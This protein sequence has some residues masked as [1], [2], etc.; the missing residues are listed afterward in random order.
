VTLDPTGIVE[1]GDSARPAT[2][3]TLF[4]LWGQPLTS[5]RLAGFRGAVRAYIDGRSVAGKPAQIELRRHAEI[6]LE[7]SGYV[8]PHAS[9]RFPNGL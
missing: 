2:L 7:I 9:Y 5:S 6:V 3:G 4:A 1:V 8:A